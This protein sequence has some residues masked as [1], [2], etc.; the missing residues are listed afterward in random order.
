MYKCNVVSS[1]TS[2]EEE[3]DEDE[4]EPFST[5]DDEEEWCEPTITCTGCLP[6]VLNILL[7]FY[8]IYSIIYII[9]FT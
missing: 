7:E 5:S 2:D 3:E 6:R 1:S 9:M 8:F 4:E